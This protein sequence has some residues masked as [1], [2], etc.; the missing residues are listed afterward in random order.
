MELKMILVVMMLL[1]ITC[2]VQSAG[3]CDI[4]KH[5]DSRFES[6]CYIHPGFLGAVKNINLYAQQCRVKVVITSSFRKDNGK[7][8]VG[9]VYKPAKRSNHFVGHAIDMN[10]TDGN[11]F[12]NSSCLR[13]EKNHPKGV[14]CFIQK[15][16][17]DA[18]LR[19]GGV[20]WK[21]DPVHIDDKLNYKNE[22]EYNRLFQSLQTNCKHLPV[23]G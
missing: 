21:P 22:A 19:W 9:A 1:A 14:K 20:F 16:K 3:N 5:Q 6:F 10:L 8:L 12:C 13:D 2:T 7:K 23:R 4:L 15:I 18:S 11:H 17:Q